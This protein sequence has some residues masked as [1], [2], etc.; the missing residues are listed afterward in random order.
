ME[1]R[2][3]LKA[4][5]DQAGLMVKL[6]VIGGCAAGIL[7][8]VVLILGC[9]K[10]TLAGSDVFAL[11]VIPFSLAL[12]FA[13]SALIYGVMNRSAAREEEEKILLEKRKENHAF[14]VEEDV[15]FTA[16]RSF[17]NYRKYAPYVLA[18]LAA[19][20]TVGVLLLFRNHWR[21]RLETPVPLS[22]VH[23]AMVSGFLM[24]VAVFSG[25]F[26]VGQSRQQAYRW[27][28]PVGGWLIAGFGVLLC[29][30]VSSICQLQGVPQFDGYAARWIWWIFMVL[31]CEFIFN[32]VVEFYRPRTLEE[33]RPIFESRLLSFFTE[34]GG[35]MRNLA[36]SLDYQ[37]GF[38]VSG[39]WLYGF[40]ERSVFPLLV[41]WLLLL[42]LF[43]GINEVG[44]GQV[45]VHERFG[46]VVKRELLPPGVY[47]TLP[48]PFA[49]ISRYS[50]EEIKTVTIG[51][52]DSTKPGEEVAHQKSPVILWTKQ[53]LEGEAEF[54]V[55]V[56][57]E[58]SQE[59]VDSKA[60]PISFLGLTMPVQYQIRPEGLFRYAYEN[61]DPELMLKRIGQEV[62]TEYFASSSIFKIMSTGRREAENAIRERIQEHADQ[63]GLGIQVVAVNILDA[64]PPV[65][66]VAPAFQ[67]VIGAMETMHSTVLKAEAY[68]IKTAAESQSQAQQV[69]ADAESYRYRV[70]QVA[71]AEQ[72]RFQSQLISYQAFPA[73]FKLNVYLDML[74]RDA[75]EVRKFVLSSGLQ[76]EVYELNFEEKAR[77]DLIDADLNTLVNKQ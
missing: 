25:A 45:G 58:T 71:Q 68:Q 69:V 67:E 76:N 19:L 33:P 3:D 22:A 50:C 75:G 36:D 5:G 13:L 8:V 14:E 52:P 74:L 10:D 18:I 39:T 77:F 41:I 57:P 55:A 26:F 46:R 73:L 24:C 43:T 17:A 15:R 12:L 60:A 30:T 28:R 53:H 44:P 37:F 54:V 23:A 1:I 49:R 6:S 51:E 42:W 35:V 64:H 72:A 27:L 4:V 38:K 59:A 34:P 62:A 61:R 56:E 48:Y 29:A 20:F 70:T 40:I 9:I 32:F 65:E 63:V 16:G 11:S 47:Y 7:T 21:V 2:K 66:K 31:G